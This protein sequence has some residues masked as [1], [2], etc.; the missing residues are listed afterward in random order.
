[1]NGL[2]VDDYGDGLS[3]TYTCHEIINKELVLTLETCQRLGIRLKQDFVEDELSR[4]AGC[5]HFY[6]K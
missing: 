3:A 5:F 2:I 6:T 4:E 1:M